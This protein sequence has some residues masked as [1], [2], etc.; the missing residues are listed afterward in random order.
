M[1][2]DHA[3]A[4][5]PQRRT[6]RLPGLV[7]LG[8]AFVLSAVGV[9]T[10]VGYYG[11][12]DNRAAQ[13]VAKAA[14]HAG[15]AYGAHSDGD[16]FG[17]LSD[18]LLPLP[19]GYDYGP[20]DADLGDNTVLTHDQYVK[21]FNSDFAVLRTSER[22][23]LRTDL[24]LDHV[25]GYAL[26]TYTDGNAL[27]VEVS[28]VQENQQTA[29]SMA[30]LGKFLADSTGAFRAGPSI[31]G[32]PEAH[33]YLLPA[34]PNDPLDQMDCDDYVGD[35]LVHVDAYGPAPLDQQS[36]AS[37]LELQLSRL[38]IPAAQI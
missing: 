9:G 8:A 25:L 36:V 26:R 3:V 18:L 31:P 29:K 30:T 4:P 17:S 34:S 28:L 38:A 24:D 7:A 23:K 16:H 37:L 15:P 33:C 2:D 32:H 1:T 21:K 19:G 6:G 12:R 35:M 5:A 13:P 11:L 20:D 22:D 27:V 10:A 14:A